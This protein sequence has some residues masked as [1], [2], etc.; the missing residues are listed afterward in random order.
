MLKGEFQATAQPSPMYS[1]PVTALRTYWE[2]SQKNLNFRIFSYTTLDVVNTLSKSENII[3]Y[4]DQIPGNVKLNN[5][6]IKSLRMNNISLE[7]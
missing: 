4:D 5:Y 3:I 1:G 7:Q 2:Q 6:P